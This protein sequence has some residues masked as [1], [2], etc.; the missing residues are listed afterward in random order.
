MPR[1]TLTTAEKAAMQ[2]ARV[3][4]RKEKEAARCALESNT[5]FS[6]PKFWKSLDPE[7]VAAIEKAMELAS[8]ARKKDKI[9]D[10]EK[11]LAKLKNEK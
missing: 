6:N 2:K 3:T 10:L 7:L 4:A 11:Q 5:Q 1:R 8:K 9:R